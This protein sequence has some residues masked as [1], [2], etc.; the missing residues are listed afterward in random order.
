LYSQKPDIQRFFTNVQAYVVLRNSWDGEVRAAV[1]RIVKMDSNAAPFMVE[2]M[3]AEATQMDKWCERVS[4]KF[5][6]LSAWMPKRRPGWE[7]RLVGFQILLRLGPRAANEIPR[8]SRALTDPKHQHCDE[9]IQVLGAIGPAAGST[10]V[11]IASHLSVSNVTQNVFVAEALSR[12]GPAARS[13]APYLLDALTRGL[14]RER[15]ALAVISALE[16]V[17]NSDQKT[18]GI[19]IGMRQG[20]PRFRAAML[21]KLAVQGPIVVRTVPDLVPFLGDEWYFV[22]AEAVRALGEIA[23]DD[24]GVR[25]SLERL[26]DDSNQEVR[27]AARKVLSQ[28]VQAR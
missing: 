23:P 7:L 5:P 21:R 13:T 8:L 26:Q 18:E 25:Q 6:N 16:A 4:R 1:D 10:A 19:L 22:R 11:T 3:L 12:I 20:D 9:A 28:P 14:V 2:W 17:G 27:E 15:D 24:P